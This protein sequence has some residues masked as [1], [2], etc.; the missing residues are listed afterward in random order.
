[1]SNEYSIRTTTVGDKLTCGFSTADFDFDN[2]EASL[3][4]SLGFCTVS[5]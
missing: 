2:S 5:G 4:G 1:M 3:M